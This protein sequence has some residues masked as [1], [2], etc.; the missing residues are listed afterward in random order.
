MNHNIKIL[1]VE[2]EIFASKYL[3]SI[4]KSLGYSKIFEATN[5]NDALEI[6]SQNTINLCFMDI[7]I[8]G[9]I[10][11]IQCAKML[12]NK[13]NIPIIYTTAYNDSNTI[14]EASQTNIY[15]Y[16]I[17]PFDVSN[18]E[19]MLQITLKLSSINNSIQEEKAIENLVK[20]STFICYDIEKQT[21]FENNIPIKFT[22]KELELLDYFCKSPNQNISYDTLIKIIWNDKDIS[23]STI[24]D[25]ISRIKKKIK[26]IDLENINNF[27]YILHLQSE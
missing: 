1:I 25:I 22:K 27:G 6:A 20:I 12:N 2:D 17:K 16:L 5:S 4:L 9:A 13:Y 3:A 8:K 14:K 26:N 19:A 11:G 10:D 23:H 21:V 24:R 7:N 15:G 18:V